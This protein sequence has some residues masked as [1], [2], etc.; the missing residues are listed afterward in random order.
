[1]AIRILT[2]FL[3]IILLL[4]VA[5][6]A[7]TSH[8][9]SGRVTDNKTGQ[10]IAVASVI[11]KGT[12]QGTATD[13]NGIFKIS[14]P[15]SPD[16]TLIISMVGYRKFE[17]EIGLS[18]KQSTYVEISLEPDIIK[19]NRLDSSSPTIISSSSVA[20]RRICFI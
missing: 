5:V 11:I 1:M 18:E 17:L 16:I 19:L 12:S 20:D 15:T 10:P 14:V 2:I 6:S 7:Q 13:T 3:S 8:T 4:P 9:V